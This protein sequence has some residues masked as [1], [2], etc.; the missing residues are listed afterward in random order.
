MR[1]STAP[2][3]TLIE[4]LVVIAIIAILAAIL[5]PVFAQAKVSANRTVSLSNMKQ[6]GL[7]VT[8]YATDYDDVYP[9]W[10]HGYATYP[11]QLDKTGWEY[12][13]KYAV[14]PYIKSGQL[15]ETKGENTGI[16]RC[17]SIPEWKVSIDWNRKLTAPAKVSYGINMGIAYTYAPRPSGTT[18]YRY[19]PAGLVVE[20]AKTVWGGTAGD[21]TRLDLPSNQRWLKYGQWFNDFRVAQW[22]RRDAFHGGTVYFFADGHASFQKA[23]R[24]YPADLNGARRAT[25]EFFAA[26]SD[27]IDYLRGL[28]GL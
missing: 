18:G 8:M 11:Y 19:L 6:I 4:L 13:W 25:I 20:P 16:W 15:D 10:I 7:G 23:D 3:F 5:F 21:A 27:N 24:M 1:R 28:W 12:T 9:A 22:E 2:A 14:Q 17:P 26:T